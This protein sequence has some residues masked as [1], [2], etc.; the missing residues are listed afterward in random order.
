MTMLCWLL[1]GALVTGALLFWARPRRGL[2]LYVLVEADAENIEWLLTLL[3]RK[4]PGRRLL[5]IDKTG[6][7]NR[8][9]LRAL[10]R[11]Y[12][13]ESVAAPP[14]G[15]PTLY[16]RRGVTAQGLLR[17]YEALEADAHLT[18]DAKDTYNKTMP[19]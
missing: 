5:I 14:S 18:N 7:E 13:L 19:E 16:A 4:A 1:A 17:Q 9:I 2:P 15:A 12:H 11:R 8:R 10:A 6:G 3:L